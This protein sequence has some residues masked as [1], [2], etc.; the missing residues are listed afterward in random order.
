MAGRPRNF[1]EQEVL[2]KALQLFWQ[3][4]YGATGIADL[5]QATGLGRQSLYGAFGDKRALFERVVQ[6]YFDVVLRAGLIEVLDAEGSPR[7]NIETIFAAWEAMAVAPDFNGCLVGNA[8][9][10]VGLH[11]D[12]LASVLRQKLRLMEDA[13][14]RA[15]KRGQ[16]LLEFPAEMDARAV[17]RSIVTTGQ[18]LAVVARVQREPAFVRAVL[19][20]ARQL[21]T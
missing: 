10:E 3:K 18:G 7:K 14:C 20:A 4:G 9:A 2:D 13:F 12:E 5:E 19:Y 11:D 15:L 8:V 16:R 21:L 1:D 17:A 6:R